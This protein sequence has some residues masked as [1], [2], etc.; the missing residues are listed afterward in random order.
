LRVRAHLALMAATV[1]VPVVL[2][3][4]AGLAIL[5]RAERD[6]TYAAARE[7]SA[8]IALAVDRELASA[9]AALKVL[10]TSQYLALGDLEAFREQA[11]LARTSEFAW[12]VLFDRMAMQLVN[13]RVAPGTVARRANPEVVAQVMQSLK[14]QVSGLYRGTLARREIIAV[15]VPVPLEGGQRYVLSHQFY[16]EYFNRVFA[17]RALPA[18]W[19]A[20]IYD[21]TGKTIAESARPAGAVGRPAPGALTEAMAPRREGHVGATVE[22][23]TEVIASFSPSRHSGWSASVMV[24]VQTLEATARRAVTVAALG[25]IAALGIA[26]L[27]AFALGRR[28][29][30]AIAETASSA[31]TLAKGSAPEL[32]PTGIIEIDG[33][34]GALARAGEVLSGERAAREQAE[35]ERQHLLASEQAARRL[36]ETQNEAKDQFLAML[37]HELRNPLSAISGAVAVM[38]SGAAP[39]AADKRAR[40]VIMR[41]SAHLARIVDDLLDMSRVMTGKVRLDIQR[42]DLGEATQRCVATLAAAGRTARHEINL[43]TVSA[44]VDAD[45]TRLDQVI[46]NILI[47]AIKY[48]PES[49]RIDAETRVEGDKAVLSVRDTGIGIA[50]ELLPRIFEVFI[51]GPA[52]LD[53]SQGGLGLGLALVQRLVQMHGG[54]VEARSDGEGRGAE[55]TMRLP[56]MP[57]PAPR[58]SEAP[59]AP[60][61]TR[62]CV[63]LVDDHDDA[64]GMVRVMLELLGYQVIEAGD[65][66]KG[67]EVAAS[68]RPDVAVVDIGLPGL[69][70]YEVAR[71]LRADE[72]TRGMGLIALTG[73]GQEED[74]RR[75]LAAGFDEH[76]V[77]PVEPEALGAAIASALS[78]QPAS[79]ERPRPA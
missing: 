24:P 76:L 61:A 75:A 33:L 66:L 16:P 45:A 48:T 8:A 12:I 56:R 47:N 70:G 39:P 27:G 67:V 13:T 60:A 36:A 40:D 64:R 63:L 57:S 68:Q 59:E 25:L 31:T 41:Q 28:L 21:A 32:A 6:A 1:L 62:A 20:A 15:D 14:P 73:Y 42:V 77:K 58:R 74:R 11:H 29:E 5:L 53:R 35:T 30:N 79:A 44:W 19:S 2:L 7:A 4:A 52:S 17:E 26:V 22:D 37:G 49:G 78:D 65:G 10:A 51:Q 34:R 71:R 69:D 18:S 54:S 3:F 55:F 23:G 38:Q 43:R 9:E 46:C 50:P 72:G